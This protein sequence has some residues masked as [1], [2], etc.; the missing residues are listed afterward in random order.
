MTKVAFHVSF[1][2]A[3]TLSGLLPIHPKAAVIV[4]TCLVI[5]LAIGRYLR[6]CR[7]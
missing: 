3:A 4:C 7:A 2:Y 6:Y 5:P 1:L